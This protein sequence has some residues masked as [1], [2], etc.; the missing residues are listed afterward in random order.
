VK[1]KLKLII[2]GAFLELFGGTFRIFLMI[3]P[4]PRT[5]DSPRGCEP[6]M[7]IL[8]LMILSILLWPVM[9]KAQEIDRGNRSLEEQQALSQISQAEYYARMALRSLDTSEKI[10]KAPY[11]N[12]QSARE[13]IEKVISELRIYLKGDESADLLPAVPLIVDGRYFSESIQNFLATRK[14]DEAQAASNVQSKNGEARALASKTASKNADAGR[15]KN[16][17]DKEQMSLKQNSSM[18]LPL[19]SL[20][21]Q[22]AK[23]KRDKIEEILKRGL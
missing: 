13:D 18:I 1:T 5:E 11:F 17:S 10:G 19:P 12:Y 20:T 3:N 14:V 21:P 9:I 16:M 4:S 22:S 2:V 7:K 15:K 23:T 8:E 6:E